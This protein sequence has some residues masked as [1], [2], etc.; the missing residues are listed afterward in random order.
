[1]PPIQLS[2]ATSLEE[3]LLMLVY[4]TAVKI[5]VLKSSF[6]SDPANYRIYAAEL[7]AV[8]APSM[9]R[10]RFIVSFLSSAASLSSV[11]HHAQHG[12]LEVIQSGHSKQISAVPVRCHCRLPYHRILYFLVP[13]LYILQV[14]KMAFGT[15]SLVVIRQSYC[16]TRSPMFSL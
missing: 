15:F 10:R 11:S 16:C 8:V 3:L 13:L 5:R 12:L 9:V 14:N 2:C 1:M 4:Q 7:F 6:T